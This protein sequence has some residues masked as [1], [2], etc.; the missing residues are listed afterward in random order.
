MGRI[1]VDPSAYANPS[2]WQRQAAEIRRNSPVLRV[3]E[4]GFP[5]FWAI[6]RHEDVMR[7]SQ[8]ADCFVPAADPVLLPAATAD[9][10]RALGIQLRTVVHMSGEEHAEYRRLTNDWFKPASLKSLQSTID[11]IAS[12]FVDRLAQFD[13]TV[14]LA[15]EVAMPFPLHVIMKI[16]G[17]PQEDEPLMLRLTQ[18]MFAPEDPEYSA[19]MEAHDAAIMAAMLDFGAYFEQIVKD[20]RANP[21]SDLASVIANGT[22]DGMPIGDLEA[23]SY[24]VVIATAGHDTTAASLNGGLEQLLRHPDQIEKL[25]TSSDSIPNAVEETIRWSTP[26]RHFMRQAAHPAVIGDTSIEKGDL[27]LLS[28]LSANFDEEVFEDPMTFDTMRRNARENI[29]FGWGKHHCLGSQLARME[30]RA[31]LREFLNRVEDIEIAGEPDWASTSFIGGVKHL[32]VR[33]RLR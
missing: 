22:I 26:V 7:V 15:T 12:R 10:N 6:T 17:I 30:L 31:F 5:P 25:R 32:P 33:Y 13:G 14:D 11:A 9:H 29:A 24:Y 23:I 18:E 16:L 2:E 27:V 21:G 20:R 8:Q 19:N 28:Y 1:F 4:E 3:E